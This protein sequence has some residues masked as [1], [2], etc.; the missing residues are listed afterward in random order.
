MLAV[1]LFLSIGAALHA[2][3]MVLISFSSQSPD[4]RVESLLYLSTG[5]ELVQA[6]LSSTRAS[7]NPDYVLSA[8]YESGDG[9]VTVHF[10]LSGRAEGGALSG[11]DFSAAL[12]RSL[13]VSVAEAVRGLLASAGI[14]YAPSPDAKM[15][16]VLSWPQPAPTPVVEAPPVAPVQTEPAAP[17]EPGF[18][19]PAPEPAL[20]VSFDSSL[21]TSGIILLG[22]FSQFT[23][24]GFSA[25]V[26][27]GISLQ[28]KK[29][30][31]VIDGRGQLLRAFTNAD[32][33]GGPLYFILLGPDIRFGTG[34]NS[35]LRMM[36]GISSGAALIT[37]T[38]ADGTLTK[39][40]PYAD[41]G[42]L[43]GFPLGDS[44]SVDADARF[45]MIFDD[46]MIVMGISAAV[47][48]RMEL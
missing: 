44:F 3:P 17:I 29:L 35:A 36:G 8:A 2:A 27:A 34:R 14:A 28:G 33:I 7:D 46:E 13:D 31:I 48:L 10:A 25:A 16:G 9:A 6:G 47:G 5:T 40:R 42:L 19:T 15:E 22:D 12:D 45:L 37:I 32:V 1:C 43:I 4:P 11:L 18:Q 39:T 30:G 20:T 38:G 21:S 41:A 24:F 26:D 23:R